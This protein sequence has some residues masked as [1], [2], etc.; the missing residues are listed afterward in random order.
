MRLKV[1]KLS[2]KFKGKDNWNGKPGH[3]FAVINGYNS[4]DITVGSGITRTKIC[5]QIV[6][7]MAYVLS[8]HF[9]S[10][11]LGKDSTR[12][13]SVV[14]LLYRFSLRVISCPSFLVISPVKSPFSFSLF[15]ILLGECFHHPSYPYICIF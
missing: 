4:G 2:L 10:F 9:L 5:L 15:Q 11:F 1:S 8:A 3:P 13:C 6:N 12:L 14:L 7:Q